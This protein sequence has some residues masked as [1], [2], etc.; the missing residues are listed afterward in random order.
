MKSEKLSDESIDDSL[1]YIEALVAFIDDWKKL[2]PIEKRKLLNNPLKLPLY[3]ELCC[4]DEGVNHDQ[5]VWEL[6]NIVC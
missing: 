4:L 3:C 1:P 2:R 6:T 5:G